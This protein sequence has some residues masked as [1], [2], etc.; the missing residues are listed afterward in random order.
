LPSDLSSYGVKWGID[1]T[2]LLDYLR[3]LGPSADHA[4]SDAVSRWWANDGEPTIDGWKDVGLRVF[5]DATDSA[6][7]RLGNEA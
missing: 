4:L 1:E 5:P 6:I 2:A 7:G 3:S